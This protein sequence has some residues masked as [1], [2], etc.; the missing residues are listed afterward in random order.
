VLTLL[1]NAVRTEQERALRYG[2]ELILEEDA[3]LPPVSVDQVQIG[4]VLHNLLANSIEAIRD[5]GSSVRK[6]SLSAAAARDNM[7]AVTVTDSGPGL[8]SGDVEQLFRPFSSTKTYGLGLGLSMSRSIVEAHGGH[9]L[10][11]PGAG[12][13]SFRVTLP[14][15]P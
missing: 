11:V 6:I 12:G 13:S 4:M 14:V 15:A 10:F 9:L 3:H 7:V 2:V 8:S 1:R 5:A